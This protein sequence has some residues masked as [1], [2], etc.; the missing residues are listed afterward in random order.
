MSSLEG[1]SGANWNMPMSDLDVCRSRQAKFRFESLECWLLRWPTISSSDWDEV[2]SPHPVGLIRF[3]AA[4][5]MYSSRDR[6]KRS[7]A[8]KKNTP[9]VA[10]DV[11]TRAVRLWDVV[12]K[13]DNTS[14]IEQHIRMNSD[15]FASNLLCRLAISQ[16][17]VEQCR[18]FERSMT[19]AFPGISFFW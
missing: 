16:K 18:V 19:S 14:Q 8:A 10:E 15:V 5:Y 2:V 1:A 13:A 3:S 11:P 12:A 9:C 4:G 7:P 6:P 17:P